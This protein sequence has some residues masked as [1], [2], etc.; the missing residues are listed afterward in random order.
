[1]ITKQRFIVPTIL[2]LL[3]ACASSPSSNSEPIG[4]GGTGTAGSNGGVPLGGAPSGANG[5]DATGAPCETLALPANP[6]DIIA[7]FED[8]LGTVNQEAPGRGGGFYAYRDDSAGTV[9]PAADTGEAPAATSI[10]RCSSTFALCMNGSGFTEWGAGLG[11][12]MGVTSGSSKS[13]YDASQYS[14]IA[15][16]A[17]SASG[18][19]MR[20]KFPDKSTSPDGGVCDPNVDGDTYCYN[21]WGSNVTLTA[22]WMPYTISFSS[23]AQEPGWGM[24]SPGFDPSTLYSLQFQFS[25]TTGAEFSFCIDDLILVR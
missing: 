19:T 13:P 23:L 5:T 20:V 17:K 3:V 25:D 22:E 24:K 16:W 9:T 11:T 6:N 12:D 2:I 18:I 15:F 8:G 4:G 1:M 14:G 21:D 10:L 7:T